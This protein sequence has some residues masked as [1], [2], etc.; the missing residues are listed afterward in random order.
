MIFLEHRPKPLS[1]WVQ[2][3]WYACA[4]ASAPGRD[5]VLPTGNIQ[6]VIN[7]AADSLTAVDEEDRRQAI[8]PS[9]IA[10]VRRACEFLDT[11]DYAEIMG[12]I[13]RPGGLRRFMPEPAGYF[14]FADTSLEDVWGHSARRLRHRLCEAA[15][16]NEK[17]GILA[18]ELAARLRPTEP[19]AAVLAALQAILRC[20]NSLTVAGLAAQS[21]LSAR[22]LSELFRD[23]VGVAPKLFSRILRFQLAVRQLHHGVN[24]PWSELALECGYYDQSHFAHDFHAFSG[25]SPTTYTHHRG[26]WA[27]HVRS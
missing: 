16:P 18:A 17:L 12:I 2:S 27:N 5:R 25:I 21:G 4:P 8:A 10:G 7:L 15:V 3:I 1:A 13:F 11:R 23:E 20:P 19:H 14:S 9:L 6:I 24:V 26:P 22:R